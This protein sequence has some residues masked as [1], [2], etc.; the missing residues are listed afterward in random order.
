[1]LKLTDTQAPCGSHQASNEPVHGVVAA[2]EEE[3]HRELP[4]LAQRGDL[5]ELGQKVERA[6]RGAEE[7]VR[8]GGGE[9]EDAPPQGVPAV[10]V[11]AQEEAA[12]DDDRIGEH[13]EEV[14]GGSTEYFSRQIHRWRGGCQ[15]AEETSGEAGD[16]DRDKLGE[17]KK[18]DGAEICSPGARPGGGR[19][20]S[21]DLP[22][23]GEEGDA[24]LH[25]EGGRLLQREAG[26]RLR[27][28]PH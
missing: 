10:Q 6:D 12:D 22:S 20:E 2:G 16:R 18:L 11:P 21:G 25:Q 15:E 13:G 1:M 24:G 14:Q 3:D 4:G 5:E 7:A 28:H 26:L 27:G 17:G 9:A 19:R 8:R 23:A